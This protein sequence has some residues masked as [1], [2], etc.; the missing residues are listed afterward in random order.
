MAGNVFYIVLLCFVLLVVWA[1]DRVLL[2]EVDERRWNTPPELIPEQVIKTADTK[3]ERSLSI[4]ITT[5]I[6]VNTMNN[7]QTLGFQVAPDGISY[8]ENNFNRPLFQ[9]NGGI[10]Q[11]QSVSLALGS[12][13]MHASASGSIQ[14]G[15]GIATSI[16]SLHF[17]APSIST[18][19]AFPYGMTSIRFPGH[20]RPTWT[21]IRP[22]HNNNGQHPQRMPKL[23]IE[24]Q[25]HRKQNDGP[26]TLHISAHDMRWNNRQPQIRIHKWQPSYRDYYD[27]EQT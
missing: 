23:D 5:N 7:A 4:P 27:N 17:P 13:A 8:S 15:H 16:G 21:N 3:Y 6:N 20:N 14:N 18:N 24:V 11:S 26:I 1:D 9:P 10:S 19:T 25:P 2:T 22:N 12:T